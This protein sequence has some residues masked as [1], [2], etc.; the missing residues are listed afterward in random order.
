MNLII[1]D[2]KDENIFTPHIEFLKNKK[3]KRPH[4]SIKDASVNCSKLLFLA[5][6]L[7]KDIISQLKKIKISKKD[8]SF[9][10]LN[11]EKTNKILFELSLKNK[12]CSNNLL[13]LLIKLNTK[14][15]GIYETQYLIRRLLD[16]CKSEIFFQILLYNYLYKII[17]SV[18]AVYLTFRYLNQPRFIKKFFHFYNINSSYFGKYFWASGRYIKKWEIVYEILED[19]KL[20]INL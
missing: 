6:K 14:F 10:I 15:D 11:N 3:R 2:S 4:S 13:Y 8:K 18:H 19:Q 5:Q 7:K 12:N 16:N 17:Y 20:N 1:L 9:L